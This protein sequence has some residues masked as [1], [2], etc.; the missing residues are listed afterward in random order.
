MTL[1]SK[2]QCK[3]ENIPHLENMCSQPVIH[4]YGNFRVTFVETLIKKMP[5]FCQIND[6]ATILFHRLNVT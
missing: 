5:Y 4:Y 1:K 2:E 6:Y 3:S